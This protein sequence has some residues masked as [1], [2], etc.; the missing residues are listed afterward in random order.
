VHKKSYWSGDYFDER[1]R[2]AVER[3]LIGR[4]H[5]LGYDVNI[6]PAALSL[7]F[8][9]REAQLNHIRFTRLADNPPLQHQDAEPQSNQAR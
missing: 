9:F 2:T 1:D 4:L 5:K 7:I 6:Q 8:I 3:R